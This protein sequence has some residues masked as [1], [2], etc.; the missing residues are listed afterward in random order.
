M[1]KR[2]VVVAPG[3][4]GPTY[5]FS[6]ETFREIGDYEVG[7]LTKHE[8]TCFNCAVDIRKYRVTVELIDEPVEVLR[9]RVKK[10]WREC[11]NHHHWQALRVVAANL[12]IELD[13]AEM[14]KARKARP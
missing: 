2:K 4:S 6:F 9:E 13:R 12:G 7:S 3:P 5:P 14:D 11:D 8:P 1:S 10:L